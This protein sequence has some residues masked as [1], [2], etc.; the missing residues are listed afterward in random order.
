LIIGFGPCT[1]LFPTAFEV[2]PNVERIKMMIKGI[3]VNGPPN[4]EPAPGC[5]I[6]RRQLL[7]KEFSMP[8]VL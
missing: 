4:G 2:S 6:L 5:R 7:S 1:F 8:H 3:D